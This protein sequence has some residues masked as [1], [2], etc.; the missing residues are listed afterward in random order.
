[1]LLS[2]LPACGT[3]TG[4]NSNPSAQVRPSLPKEM[5]KNFE[6]WKKSL[7]KDCDPSA[8]LSGKG[9]D[10]DYL[11][12]EIIKQ[13]LD[14]PFLIQDNRGHF[15]VLVA[16]PV[17]GVTDKT[18][19]IR[20][21]GSKESFEAKAEIA[22][23]VC[24]LSIPGQEVYE[25]PITN[26]LKVVLL[27][28]LGVNFS[29]AKAVH[30]SR[31]IKLEGTQFVHENLA[32]GDPAAED[33][34]TSELSL[35]TSSKFFDF[36]SGPLDLNVSQFEPLQ[37]E[38]R[39]VTLR[40]GQGFF[41]GVGDLTDK[42]IK[43]A[44]QMNVLFAPD[45]SSEYFL[46]LS[47]GGKVELVP[48][49]S[50]SE[51]VANC[52]LDWASY[53]TSPQ[54]DFFEFLVNC[55]SNQTQ[56][57]IIEKMIDSRTIEEFLARSRL[58][59]ESKGNANWQIFLKQV[60][61]IIYQKKLNATELLSPKGQFPFL[62]RLASNIQ[63]S[64]DYLHLDYAVT[65]LIAWS[66]NGIDVSKQNAEV[67]YRALPEI[68]KQYPVSDSIEAHPG[69]LEFR[70]A[71]LTAPNNP[72]TLT[73][74][75]E[76]SAEYAAD[77]TELYLL[78]SS[79]SYSLG[80]Q[81]P[82]QPYTHR[83][84]LSMIPLLKQMNSRTWSD[85]SYIR[86]AFGKSLGR[87]M[88]E[89]SV[90]LQQMTSILDQIQKLA[91]IDEDV[92]REVGRKL[93]E[94]KMSLL[95]SLEVFDFIRAIDSETIA[96]IQKSKSNGQSINSWSFPLANWIVNRSSFAM[97]LETQKR[98]ADFEKALLSGKFPDLNVLKI[99]AIIREAVEENWTDEQIRDF[100]P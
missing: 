97:A 48:N 74:A 26:K 87:W 14:T 56:T 91:N 20:S 9:L 55:K 80:F 44:P 45:L 58:T 93:A 43:Y 33:L 59:E 25:F 6:I 39:G 7:K 15:S 47:Y 34:F 65:H 99:E 82:D 4:P 51:S 70:L 16:R 66:F 94:K 29:T 31:T 57:Q 62:R 83:E 98:M 100:Q 8:A 50:P 60:V 18:I 24:K 37:M 5:L 75:K 73:A 71:I 96:T 19:S 76:F 64:S 85:N 61:A 11:D 28:K 2:L 53:F 68:L 1:M 90:T 17:Y 27:G 38:S 36:S 42:Q 41:A 21:S 22:N 88:L 3:S 67:Y 52:V 10:S 69:S 81:I 79:A 95:E 92:A 32:L 30:D 13:S 89:E 63:Q 72:R 86:A 54:H 78:K 84:I 23:S 12:L 49:K 77:L 35:G 40:R 46:K